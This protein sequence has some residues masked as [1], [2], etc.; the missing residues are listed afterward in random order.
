MF[1]CS[2]L[3]SYFIT[4]KFNCIFLYS[5]FYTE[6][7][8]KEYAACQ[9]NE[10][11]KLDRSEALGM[12]FEDWGMPIFIITN[13]THISSI[14]KVVFCLFFYRL[15]YCFGNIFINILYVY[16]CNYCIELQALPNYYLKPTTYYFTLLFS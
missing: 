3:L 7:L 8:N 14:K 12:M 2:T 6:K 16:V 5:G 9:K 11:N 1:F 10:W 13:E 4:V 15:F